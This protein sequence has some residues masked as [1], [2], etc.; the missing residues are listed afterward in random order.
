MVDGLIVAP[1]CNNCH[2]VHDILPAADPKSRVHKERV[3]KTC[4][5]CHVLV[6]EV[7]EKS[8]HGQ[9][10]AQFDQ[11]GPVC[12]TCHTSHQIVDPSSPQFRLQADE[13]CGSCHQDRL[14]NYRE[15][16]HGKA[17]ALGRGSVA[18]CYDC[19]GHHDVQMSSHPASHV[20]PANR[21]ATCRKCHAGAGA[22]F[23]GYIVHADHTDKERYPLLY[24]VYFF[25]TLLLLGT[26]VFFA[27]HSLL[28]LFRSAAL[29]TGDS[30]EFRA[31]K[32]KAR[33]DPE[34]FVR[35]RPLDRFLHALIISSFLLLVITG[36]PLKFYYMPWASWM[37]AVMGGQQVAGVIHRVGAIITVFY[38]SVHVLSVL[39]GFL[40]G[41][42]RWRDPE[43]G[44]LSLRRVLGIV[45]G[46]DSPFPN[47]QDLRDFWAHQKFF[48]GKGP[49]PQFDRWT[50]WEKFD[51]MAVFWGVFMIGLSGLVM[52][53]PESMTRVL[54][55][56][57]IN[58]AMII[59]SDEALLAAGF[60]F[61]FHFFNVH[62]RPE[63]FP[64][65]PVIFSG[66]ISKTE[67]M[68]ERK[69]QYDRWEAAGEVDKH[70]VKD[71]WESWKWIALPA[72]FIAFCIGVGL[73]VL[74]FYAMAV[75]LL[76]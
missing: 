73:V 5:T 29:F 60:I 44:R 55:G 59:H 46:P 51:Y 65:D 50:Y 62:F 24:W 25:M 61:T 41:R 67:M 13:R 34:K 74:I 21:E 71:E 48:F 35:F 54:P 30:R 22:N 32:E 66:R 31:H 42:S 53:F 11:R 6:E 52:W 47:F 10:L 3:A 23:A 45:F 4:G 63:K 19:H 40:A 72:G 18:T 26:F 57:T 15:T 70:R 58:I 38:F 12:N 75:R 16:F 43:S 49:Q 1:T 2:G 28:W 56:W 36:M 20:G 33:N 37:L 7:Y 64:L 9:L 39:V 17:M 14:E 27:I 68:H 76:A 8:I 69:R